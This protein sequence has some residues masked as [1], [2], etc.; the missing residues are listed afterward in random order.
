MKKVNLHSA[1]IWHFFLVE[2]ERVLWQTHKYNFKIKALCI[3]STMITMKHLN[4]MV[5]VFQVNNAQKSARRLRVRELTQFH[6]SPCLS[7]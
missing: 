5:T 7:V 1:I 6:V 2:T 4:A 3:N